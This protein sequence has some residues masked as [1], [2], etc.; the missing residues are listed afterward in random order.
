MKLPKM[1]IYTDYEKGRYIW[2]IYS[3]LKHTR[4]GSCAVLAHGWAKD[5]ETAYNRAET[6]MKELKQYGELAHFCRF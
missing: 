1:K 3:T 5:E 6:K 4:D 2:R